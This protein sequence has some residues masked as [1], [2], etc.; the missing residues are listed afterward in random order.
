VVTEPRRRAKFR[1]RVIEALEER[2]LMS[3]GMH[4]HALHLHSARVNTRALHLP[5]HT[6]TFSQTNLVSDG[7][8]PAQVTD[9]NLVNSWGL[10]HSSQSPWWINDNGKGLSTL[11][12]AN[13]TPPPSFNIVPL[14]VTIPPPA[15]SPAGTTAA[16]TGIVF[17]GTSD[18]VVSQGGKS[19]ASAF[20]FATEDGT[21]SGWNPTVNLTNAVLAVDNSGSDAVYKGLANG[22]SGGANYIYATD[23]HNGKVDVFD[24]TFTPHTFSSDQFTDRNIPLGYAPFGIQNIDGM[25]FVTYAKQKPDKHDDLAGPGHGFVDV[26]STSGDLLQRVATFGPL[27]SPWGL[28]VAPSSF[29]SFAGDL[30]VGNF[31]DGRISAYRMDIPGRFIL[32]GQLKD[33]LGRPITID[34]LWGLSVGND[35][36]AGSSQTVFFT[37]GPNGEQNG[38]F[39][40]LTATT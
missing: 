40:S 4:S 30:L 32:K 25:I 14:V 16:P 27:N 9:P 26:F 34:G 11:Y 28:V 2:A 23:F 10:V 37:A 19:G 31:G 15:G 29:G 36:G 13:A 20:I 5:M 39:G 17:N 12:R 22:S 24:G 18:F 35:A 8:V 6:T 7:A 3:A 33:T 38:L 21:I 1:P